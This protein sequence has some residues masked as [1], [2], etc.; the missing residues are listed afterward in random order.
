MRSWRLMPRFSLATFR[1][2]VAVP[3]G[4]G[5]AILADRSGFG[6]PNV[7]PALLLPVAYSAYGGGLVIGLLA[8]AMHVFYTAIFFSLPGHPFQYD[9]Q[10]PGAPSGHRCGC[11]RDG[12]KLGN[13]RHKTE[14]SLRQLTAAKQDLLRL[15]SELEMRVE[16]RT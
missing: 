2:L 5:A 10:K 11:A 14:L 12:D 13:L 9:A 15:N 1:Y 3:L 4:I 7:P 6:I 8:A 16:E